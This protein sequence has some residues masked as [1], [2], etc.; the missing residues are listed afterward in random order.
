M[1]DALAQLGINLGQYAD[2]PANAGGF[3][4]ANTSEEAV[5]NLAKALEAGSITG[6]ETTNL[7][8]AGGAPLKVESLDETLKVVTFRENEIV[9]WKKIPKDK[10][11]NT[12]E[13]Y[14]QLDSYGEDRGGFILEGELPPEEDSRYIRRSQ[15]VR[16]LGVVKSVTHVLTLTKTQVNNMIDQE[17]KNGAMW[18]LRKLNRSIWKGNSEII[19]E[20]FNGLY[21]Q[22][23]KHDNA[24]YYLGSQAAYLNSDKVIDLR[25][26][27]LAEDD[28]EDGAASIIEDHGVATDLFAPPKVL[29]A[30]VKQFYGQKFIVP[31]TASTNAAI[32]GQKVEGHMT[33]YGVVNFNYDIF[34]AKPKAIEIGSPAAAATSSKSPA[35][36][37]AGGT[38]VTVVGAPAAN[39]MWEAGDAGD[40]WYAVAAVNRFGRS[41]LVLLDA[42]AAVAVA[43]GA[44]DLN[45]TAGV[46][47]EPATGYEIYRTKAGATAGTT[48]YKIFDVSVSNLTNGYE[49]AAAGSIRDNN[50]YLPDTDQAFMI[51]N[52]VSVHAFKQLA[53]LMKMD[54]AIVSTAF[55]FMVL[56][57]GTPMLF[58]PKKMVRYI[59]VGSK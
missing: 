43:G 7:T 20:E 19:P 54:L 49:G 36:P 47:A 51:Q 13:E 12:V 14:N 34:M 59:N 5:M 27:T 37:V 39:S 22:H 1:T 42:A 2:S 26:A 52:D 44:I 56:M 31:N 35:N 53:P 29:S 41:G 23:A 46:G 9:L 50:F 28:I 11:Y 17:A 21:L 40:V 33:N 48:F 3:G 25:G 58:A 18:I 55:R 24:N 6:R 15:F 4:E 10:A 8:G 30:F 16:F 38:P 57:Y 32:V 45:F